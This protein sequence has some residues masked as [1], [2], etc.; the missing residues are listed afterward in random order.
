[1][2]ELNVI[3]TACRLWSDGPKYVLI[4]APLYTAEVSAFLLSQEGVSIK[5]YHVISSYGRIMQWVKYFPNH[6]GCIVVISNDDYADDMQKIRPDLEVRKIII[7]KD[8][9]NG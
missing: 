3:R 9:V 5:E 2:N 4:D 7:E 1:M 8:I 6:I